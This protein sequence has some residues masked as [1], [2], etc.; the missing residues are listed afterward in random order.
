MDKQ[1]EAIES[2]AVGQEQISE[3]SR[4]GLAKVSRLSEQMDEL[5][6]LSTALQEML[7][8][9]SNIADQLHILS[10]N[11][12]I[13]AARAGTVYGAPFKVVA[14]EISSLSAKASRII[15]NQAESVKKIISI[16]SPVSYTHLTLPT[17]RIV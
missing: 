15:D 11:G 3:N 2:F 9:N 17:K 16:I 5:N 12:S 13:E 8:D 1:K 7:A 6:T 4:E 10:I 14:Q